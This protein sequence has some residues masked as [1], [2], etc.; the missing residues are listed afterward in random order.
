MGDGLC[1][2]Y[3]SCTEK[4][5]TEVFLKKRPSPKIDLFELL[6]HPRN[7]YIKCPELSEAHTTQCPK[8][9][10]G[11]FQCAHRFCVSVYA[12]YAFWKAPHSCLLWSCGVTLCVDGMHCMIAGLFE[13][14]PFRSQHFF[15]VY[16]VPVLFVVT[17]NHNVCSWKDRHPR[18]NRVCP[19]SGELAVSGLLGSSLF[20]LTVNTAVIALFFKVTVA[21]ENLVRDVRTRIWPCDLY[22]MM[23]FEVVPMNCCF[24]LIL[25]SVSSSYGRTRP[26]CLGRSICSVH[27]RCGP[28]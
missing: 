15:L 5:P 8:H 13:I 3:A 26:C 7:Y 25:F 9:M 20:V 6:R 14:N 18:V 21:V 1:L 10:G 16:L 4:Q 22:V 23:L 2:K 28:V 24:F 12:T 17:H 19:L 27:D 11:D